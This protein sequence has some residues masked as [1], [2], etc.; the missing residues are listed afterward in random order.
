MLQYNFIEIS[1]KFINTNAV[2]CCE[3]PCIFLHEHIHFYHK[4]LDS[5][6]ENLLH[7]S[8]LILGMMDDASNLSIEDCAS[9]KKG[10]LLFFVCLPICR[11]MSC[12][13]V[14]TVSNNGNVMTNSQ[15]GTWM[16]MNNE[17]VLAPSQ[18]HW[19]KLEHNYQT[20]SLHFLGMCAASSIFYVEPI[21]DFCFCARKTSIVAPYVIKFH[22]M[23]ANST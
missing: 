13:E 10:F 16:L 20:L 7:H 14:D 12:K 21:G 18:V 11:L 5:P 17:I 23:F 4:N 9:D 2:N 15:R 1:D 8:Q 6:V 19:A 22:G 3:I